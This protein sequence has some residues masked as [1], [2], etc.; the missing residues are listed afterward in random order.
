MVLIQGLADI[1]SMTALHGAASGN[2]AEIITKLL[3]AGVDVF[4]RDSMI[5]RT[6]KEV[7]IMFQYNAVIEAFEAFENRK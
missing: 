6:A 1:L 7:A 5:K 3:E 2:Q 4:I